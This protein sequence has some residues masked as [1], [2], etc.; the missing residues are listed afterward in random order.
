MKKIMNLEI[1]NKF[2]NSFKWIKSIKK[3]K[4]K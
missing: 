3:I 1:T 2:I 4:I